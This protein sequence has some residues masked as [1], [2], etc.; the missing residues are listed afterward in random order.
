SFR[1]ESRNDLLQLGVFLGE[2][3]L[4]SLLMQQLIDAKRQS[5]AS[6]REAEAYRDTLQQSEQRL[7]AILDHSTAAIYLK[8]QYGRYVV[9]N[10]QWEA[11]FGI[12]KGRAIGK[13]D[14]EL[15]TRELAERFEKQDE[16][17]C[18]STRATDWEDHI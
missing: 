2:G 4:V 3:I 1:V 6:T 14:R 5:E 9:T 15:F 16:A 12:A 13:T 7:Q 10:P 8:D 11:T 17:I 18:A